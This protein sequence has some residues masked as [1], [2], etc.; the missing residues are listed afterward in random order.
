MKKTLKKLVILPIYLI[1]FPV[2]CL[3]DLCDNYVDWRGPLRLSWIERAILF[4]IAW[5]FFVLVGLGERHARW[6]KEDK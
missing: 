2:G 1:A 5:L 3:F 6:I 4:P